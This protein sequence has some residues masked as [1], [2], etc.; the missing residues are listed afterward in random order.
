[1]TNDSKKLIRVKVS[2]SSPAVPHIKTTPGSKGVVGNFQFFI[3]QDVKDVDWWVVVDGFP[4]KETASCPREN[5]ILITQETEVVKTYSQK[6]IDQFHW[7]ITSQQ[8]LKHPRQIFTQQGHQSYLFLRRREAGQSLESFQ[9]QFKTYDELRAQTPADIPKSKLLST[10][11]SQKLRTEGA[12][13]RHHFVMELRKHFGDRF[14][15]FSNK[16]ADNSQNVFGPEAKTTPYKWDAVAPYKYLLSI[17]NS[18]APNWW[19]NHLFD[20]FIAGAYPIFYGHP[21]VFNYFPKNS[22]TLIDINDLPGSIATIERVFSENYFEKYQKEIWEAR[23]LVLDK[24]YL[25][26]MLAEEIAKLPAGKNPTRITLFPEQKP[27]LKKKIVETLRGKGVLYT[28]PRKLY[29]M[30]RKIRYD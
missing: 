2:T 14:D 3:D 18:Y 1:M 10:V 21:S 22:L 19:T 8:T 27:W 5:T 9:A 11:I 26:G 23:R 7:I 30:Y 6:Y 20:G 16:L 28:I 17:E 13:A 15:I 29:R 4:Q 24:Y 12:Q 25:F